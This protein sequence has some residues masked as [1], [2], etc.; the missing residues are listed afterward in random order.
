LWRAVID[1]SPTLDLSMK[2]GNL[3]SRMGKID[4]YLYSP[5]GILSGWFVVLLLWVTHVIYFFITSSLGVLGPVLKKD[6]AL[7]NSE[8]GFLNSAIAIGSTVIQIPGGLYC[9]RYGVRKM[10]SS[11]LLLIGTFFFIFSFS[12]SFLLASGFLFLVGLGVGGCQVSAAKAVMDWFPFKGRATAMGVKQT[13]VNVG[14]ILSSF[15]FPLFILLYPWSL[16]TRWGSLVALAF[17]FLFYFFYR[18]SPHAEISFS[19]EV[20][21]KDILS[22]LRN[23]DFVL[24]TLSGIFLMAVQFS[25]STYF[26]LYLNQTLYY[27]IERSGFFLALSFGTGA[28]ARVGW[29]LGSDYFLRNRESALILIGGLG[30]SVLVM[31]SLITRSSPA[32][33][34]YFLSALFGVTGMGWN[35]IWITLAGERSLKESPGLGIGLSF[36]IGSFGAILGPPFFGFLVDLF[37]SFLWSWLFSAFCMIMVIILAF[38]IMYRARKNLA[39]AI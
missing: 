5:S 28:F 23:L 6:L 36:F 24:I 13:G 38:W 22:Y 19:G 14:G 31:L 12:G 21:F 25:F 35:A 15:L 32:W 4:S 37:D 39:K 10:M 7:S 16:V 9:D 33:L 26:V 1:Q 34:I 17:A 30:A 20:H 29:S 11:G 18:N 3:S 2:E 8:L 27:S